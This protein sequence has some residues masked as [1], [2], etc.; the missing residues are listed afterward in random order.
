M[1]LLLLRLLLFVARC[2]TTTDVG[3]AA[4]AAYKRCSLSIGSSSNNSNTGRAARELGSCCTLLQE[5]CCSITLY[6]IRLFRESQ[7]GVCRKCCT[8]QWL[9]ITTRIRN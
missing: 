6:R 9:K 3:I 8:T 5:S 7:G 4:D 1:M 2:A